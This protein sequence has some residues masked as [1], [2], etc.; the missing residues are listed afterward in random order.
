MVVTVTFRQQRS[1]FG[2][3]VGLGKGLNSSKRLLW[4]VS[5]PQDL[6]SLVSEL[7]SVLNIF[8]LN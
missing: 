4:T 1:L 7:L 5:K 2:T 6:L 8:A 3:F